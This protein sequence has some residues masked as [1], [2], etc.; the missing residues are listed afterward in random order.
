M[1]NRR[2]SCSDVGGP[3]KKPQRIFTARVSKAGKKARNYSHDDD[4][5]F[6][7][8]EEE[9]PRIATL[10][11]MT[12]SQ[13]QLQTTTSK[14]ADKKSMR[15]PRYSMPSQPTSNSKLPQQE[16]PMRRS[17]FDM[18]ASVLQSGRRQSQSPPPTRQQEARFGRQR[19][20][21]SPKPAFSA[22]QS[23]IKPP[24]RLDSWLPPPPNGQK[25]QPDTP[26][27][28]CSSLDEWSVASWTETPAAAS[29]KKLFR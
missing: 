29:K 3:A 7:I 26:S 25:I 2:S 11:R 28:A 18:A 5:I 9:K 27:T 21:P 24:K 17:Q 15:R 6:S 16:M 19:E 23:T 20:L 13:I 4:N 1:S 14:A 8:V 22:F 12:G 10:E